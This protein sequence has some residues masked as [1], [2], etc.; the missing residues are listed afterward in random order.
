MLAEQNGSQVPG[1]PV[2]GL[3]SRDPM[4]ASNQVGNDQ[5]GADGSFVVIDSTGTPTN[6][7][8][9]DLGGS[10]TVQNM[11][12]VWTVISGADTCRV[13][14]TQT[15]KQGTDRN[16]ASA[17]NCSISVLASLASWKLVGSQVQFFNDSG[18]II[19]TMLRSGNRFIGTLA[20]GQGI[21]MAG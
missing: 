21:S 17:P 20:G 12:G 5:A 13:N 19:G 14:L 16:R 4:L 18:Q 15:I 2:D 1:F 10:L 6:V 8:P 11:L 9:R 7:Q 3:V